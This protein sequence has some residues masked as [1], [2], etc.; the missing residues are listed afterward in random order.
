MATVKANP[1]LAKSGSAATY[2]LMSPL[3]L[4]G[5]V[6]SKVLETFAA[7]YRAGGGEVDL[8]AAHETPQGGLNGLVTRLAH[9]VSDVAA[10][11]QHRQP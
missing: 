7:M 5:M 4:R 6:R 9:W 3:P 2:G 10:K 1:E 8:D 11:R